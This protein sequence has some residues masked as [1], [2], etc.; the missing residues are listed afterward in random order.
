MLNQSYLLCRD[1]FK[2]HAK[3]YYLGA[4]LFNKSKFRHICAFYGFVRVIDNIIDE[5]PDLSLVKK[6]DIL[7]EIE[8][9]FF[10]I[11]NEKN[12]YLGSV[13]YLDNFGIKDNVHLKLFFDILPAVLNTFKEIKITQEIVRCFFKSMRMDLYKFRYKTTTE[14]EDYMNGSA[15]IIGEVMY[16]IMEKNQSFE[17]LDYAYALG[18]SFQLTNF[19]R[20]IRE[21]YEMK[22]SRIYIP[23][24]CQEDFEVNL[25]E[26]IPKI[27]N[28]TIKEK[29]FQ[30][31]KDLIK[32]EIEKVE[33][34]YEFAQVGIDK[35]ED[36]ENIN[37]SKVLYSS[38]HNKI[39][40]NDYDVFSQRC[41]LT[42][43]EKLKISYELLSWYN[44]FR[45]IIN[46]ISYSYF[47]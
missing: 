4:V 46:Y 35:L 5:K 16:S 47:F 13:S 21:D 9:F 8:T 15:E 6:R 27:I 30:N 19:I 42:F 41:H 18:R 33:I 28:G 44:I 10:T 3:T 20:D 24:D 12:V 32:S 25:E 1:I 45:F 34:I 29:D 43:W 17:M 2:E 7:L 11:L 14:L 22:P 26:D 23:L 36:R 31:V 40:E 39:R 37:L 38:I